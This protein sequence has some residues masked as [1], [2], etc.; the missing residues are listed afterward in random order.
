MKEYN[1]KIIVDNIEVEGDGYSGYYSF[2]YKVSGD[3]EVKER[4]ES[5]FSNGDT[6]KEFK[7]YLLEEG[8]LFIVLEELG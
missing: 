6:P 1:I 2:D 5:D 3:V 8:A 4:Y 7:D